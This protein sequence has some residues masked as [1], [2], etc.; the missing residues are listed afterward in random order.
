MNPQ[1]VEERDQWMKTRVSR[2][3]VRQ[4]A[5][6]LPKE[7]S[8]NK[9]FAKANKWILKKMMLQDCMED[10]FCLM[11]EANVQQIHTQLSKI[12]KSLGFLNIYVC[13]RD[14]TTDPKEQMMIAAMDIKDSL[15]KLKQKEAEAIRE[16]DRCKA[17]LQECTQ[18]VKHMETEIQI[19][20]EVRLRQMI[21][22]EKA[23]L[24]GFSL[25]RKKRLKIRKKINKLTATLQRKQDKRIASCRR[26]KPRRIHRNDSRETK[27]ADPAILE[28]K[29]PDTDNKPT[30]KIQLHPS[31]HEVFK[32]MMV[33]HKQK[34][35]QAY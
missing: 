27:K 16:L 2:T 10:I 19:N 9:Y 13:I 21:D 12:P 1:G 32:R 11:E 31:V 22:F 23:K 3:H 29:Q 28:S 25:S 24:G 7:C 33:E 5:R 34:Q 15:E 8:R 20:E 4:I 14:E 30:K 17:H 26:P 6:V 35:S 18:K